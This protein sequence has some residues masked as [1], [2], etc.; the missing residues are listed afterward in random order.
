MDT[1]QTY[2]LQWQ[3]QIKKGSFGSPFLSAVVRLNVYAALLDVFKRYAGSPL[4]LRLL[5][6]V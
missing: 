5:A 6:F 3:M 4:F 1:S 2:T